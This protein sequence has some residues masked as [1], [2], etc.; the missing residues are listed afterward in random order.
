MK[1]VVLITGASGGLGS[2]MAKKFG[3]AGCRVVVNYNRSAD[4]A[5]KVA[6]EI[7]SGTGEAFVYQA[8]VSNYA[9]AKKMVDDTLA[10]WKRIDILVSNAGGSINLTG[11][12]IQVVAEM[13]EEIWD[14]VIDANLKSTFNCCK[15]VLPQMI[16]QRDGHIVNVAS[17]LGISGSKGR[18]SYAAAKAG[19][20][21]LTKTLA[22]E[23]G[24]DGIRLWID[25]QQL[26]DA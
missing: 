5:E 15:A 17:G 23:L 11:G 4:D 19:V 16:E 13:D 12:K 8:D 22:F 25:G 21:G 6:R 20:M 14:S 26:V 7:N 9:Q 18:A 3:T 24:D 1:K 10:K 2:A